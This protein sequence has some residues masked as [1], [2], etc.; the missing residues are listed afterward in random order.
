[1]GPIIDRFVLVLGAW[2]PLLLIGL[3]TVMNFPRARTGVCCL[4]EEN[5]DHFEAS[6]VEHQFRQI[7]IAKTNTKEQR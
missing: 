6:C 2:Y 7:K 1:M 5:V 4:A 3:F